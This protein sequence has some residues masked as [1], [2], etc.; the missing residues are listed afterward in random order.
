VQRFPV[1]PNPGLD[2]VSIKVVLAYMMDAFNVTTR[3]WKL[4]ELRQVKLQE[5]IGSW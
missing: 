5:S 1:L 3:H 2:N 4:G